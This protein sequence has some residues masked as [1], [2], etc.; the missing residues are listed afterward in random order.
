[1]VKI[2]HATWLSYHIYSLKNQVKE[3]HLNF[4]KI[5]T[6]DIIHLL[7]KMMEYKGYGVSIHYKT[8]N[9]YRKTQKRRNI[10]S[11]SNGH[12]NDFDIQQKLN[13][14]ESWSL[15]L[16]W[17]DFWAFKNKAT[18]LYQEIINYL[19]KTCHKLL[20]KLSI[21]YKIYTFIKTIT[22]HIKK[23]FKKTWKGIMYE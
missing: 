17:T 10:I 13:L 23:Y 14:I 12:I 5:M 16:V 9:T 22:G 15:A 8:L 18:E 1:M 6:L 3:K 2:K 7:W 21:K 11:S 19:D 20:D 4:D